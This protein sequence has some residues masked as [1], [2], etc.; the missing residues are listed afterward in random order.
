MD[1]IVIGS[2]KG[3]Y[4]QI[5]K[6]SNGTDYLLVSDSREP[7]E[8]G[9]WKTYFVLLDN[10]YEYFELRIVSTDELKGFLYLDMERIY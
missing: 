9:C 3:K 6:L 4:N 10:N 1:E 2:F 8:D 7:K 5:Y